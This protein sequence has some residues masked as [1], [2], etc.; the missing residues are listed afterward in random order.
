MYHTMKVGVEL[1]WYFTRC[2]HVSYDEGWWSCHDTSHAACMYYTMK[3][4]G[5]VMILRT[6]HACII[7]WRLVELSWY[8]TRVIAPRQLS[9]VSVLNAELFGFLIYPWK[10]TYG[11]EQNIWSNKIPWEFFCHLTTKSIKFLWCLENSFTSLS[12]V[13]F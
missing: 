6:L 3:V 2:M 12:C 9:E 4:G 5:V 13:T 8:F 10:I 11:F 1:S 7:R